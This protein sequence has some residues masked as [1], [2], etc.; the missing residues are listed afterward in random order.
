MSR[1]NGAHVICDRRTPFVYAL[2]GSHSW[3]NSSNKTQQLP[4]PC[5]FWGVGHSA[6]AES[7]RNRFRQISAK[8]GGCF[9]SGS[10]P[11]WGSGVVFLN[12][13]QRG[14]P[15]FCVFET[16]QINFLGSIFLAAGGNGHGTE[17]SEPG[18][19]PAEPG[20]L[21]W[22]RATSRNYSILYKTKNYMDTH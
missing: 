2:C 1:P 10:R 4:I 14:L 22:T 13:S 12:V 5:F 6:M 8:L 19:R 11:R 18:F 21:K 7:A 3:S 9:W 16:H 17:E 20:F 15:R